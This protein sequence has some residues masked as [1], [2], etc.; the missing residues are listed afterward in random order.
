MYYKRERNYSKQQGGFMRKVNES[1]RSLLEMLAV[2]AI[3]AILILASLFLFNGLLQYSQRKDTEKQLNAIVTHYRSDRLVRRRNG[4]IKLNDILP[5]AQGDTKTQSN[6]ESLKLLDKINTFMILANLKEL[7]CRDVI[8][9]GNY[10]AVS[11]GYDEQIYS[12]E[13]AKE[14]QTLKAVCDGAPVYFIYG[15]DGK[16]TGKHWIENKVVDENGKEE[17]IIDL[18]DC[19]A[20]EVMDASGTCCA[21]AQLVCGSCSGCQAPTPHCNGTTC[22]QCTE[23]IHC[24]ENTPFCV[25][26]QCVAYKEVGKKCPGETSTKY[27]ND[28]HECEECKECQTWNGY[29]CVDTPKKGLGKTCQ[30]NCECETGQCENG[31]CKKSGACT[32]DERTCQDASGSCVCCEPKTQWDETHQKCECPLGFDYDAATQK[33]VKEANL[34]CPSI[35]GKGASCAGYGAY[36]NGCCEKGLS[37]RDNTC[38]CQFS[39]QYQAVCNEICGCGNKELTCQNNQCIC[40]NNRDWNPN[41]QI[42]CPA[43]TPEYDE[44]QKKCVKTKCDKNT[45]C[46]AD[47]YCNSSGVCDPCGPDGSNAIRG[48]DE[49]HCHCPA[50]L[51]IFCGS[52]AAGRQS[53][54]K[55]GNYI[56]HEG[57]QQTTDCDANEF[58]VKANIYSVWGTCKPCPDNT[59]RT[60]SQTECNGCLECEKVNETRDGCV[61]QCGESQMCLMSSCVGKSNGQN[62]QVSVVNK[63]GATTAACVSKPKLTEITGTVNE[64][65]FYIPPVGHTFFQPDAA[66]FCEA[67]GMHLATIQEACGKDWA[68]DS[69]HDCVNISGLGLSAYHVSG[70]GSFWLDGRAGNACSSLTVTYS[71]GNN[72]EHSICGERFYPLCT[73]N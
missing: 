40:P 57:C 47:F 4:V 23:D 42:C 54:C 14:A 53:S 39:N 18:S 45:D 1:G 49:E 72:H 3:I 46:P 5:G 66:R 55:D 65:K 6:G 48:K 41:Q 58:C 30:Y 31:R 38:Q 63:S 22:V 37:C 32:A 26:N 50:G 12:P 33:C 29:A 17:T 24:P 28:Q 44:T 16:A 34:T 69:G 51:S 73:K 7:T 71:C 10:D 68:Y 67:Y 15:K 62:C 64:R 8:E 20:G 59:Y 13:E 9:A 56:C 36:E 35:F 19:P 70:S 43:K 27:C 61:P 2:L 25:D 11:K 52:T 60:P 21:Q